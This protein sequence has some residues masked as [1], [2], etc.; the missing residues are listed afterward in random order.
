MVHEA[1]MGLVSLRTPLVLYGL[2]L[3]NILLALRRLRNAMN[4]KTDKHSKSKY[5]PVY[6]ENGKPLVHCNQLVTD[7]Q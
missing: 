1:A 6:N 4:L 3:V 2:T 7:V 5:I